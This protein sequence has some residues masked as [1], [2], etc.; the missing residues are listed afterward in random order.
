MPNHVYNFVNGR[1]EAEQ[2]F[3]LGMANPEKAKAGPSGEEGTGLHT[4]EERVGGKVK[5]D[6]LLKSNHHANC[7]YFSTNYTNNIILD[8]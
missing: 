3:T 4:A 7:E 6:A 1:V 2:H 8:R 5:L